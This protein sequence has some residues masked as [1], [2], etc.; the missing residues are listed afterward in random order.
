MTRLTAALLA[1]HGWRTGV[2]T[3]P[4]LALIRRARRGARRRD[5]ASRFA[6]G[7]R[8]G[9]DRRRV[10][11]RAGAHGVRAAHRRGALALRRHGRRDGR[12]RGRARRALGRDERDRSRGRRGHRGGLDHT[13]RLGETVAEIAADKAHIIK[14]A[15]IAVLGPGVGPDAARVLLARAESSA[16][17][18]APSREPGA[19]SPAADD[20]TVRVRRARAGHDR[21]AASPGSRSSACTATTLSWPCA[22]PSYQASNAATAV[23]AAEAAVGGRARPA[24]RAQDARSGDL[25]R[26]VRARGRGPAARGRGRRAQPAGRGRARQGDRGGVAGSGQAARSW[27]SACS[28]TRTP[29]AW[30]RRSPP[31]VAG[32]VVTAPD[33][34]RA[35]PAAE[36][37]AVVSRVTGGRR[38]DRSPPWREAVL[39]ARGRRGRRRRGRPGACTPS[40][41]RWKRSARR[42]DGRRRPRRRR[43]RLRCGPRDPR[44]GSFC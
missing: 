40:V 9:R 22:R 20:L 32:F 34:P 27:C 30:S 44:S 38:A 12:A 35:L 43:R 25:P 15:S 36:L 31:V 41:R 2:Y 16:S 11:T 10:A 26:P 17:T 33:S 28:R 14:P 29:P 42:R 18:R 13:D 24:R 5:G 1:A 19:W 3:S 39:A 4:H 8:D 7:D 6:R 23:A 37:A 21:P